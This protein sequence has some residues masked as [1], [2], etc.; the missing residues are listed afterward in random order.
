MI[1]NSVQKQPMLMKSTEAAGIL[2]VSKATLHRWTKAGK[3]EC[4][5]V[6]VNSIYFTQ[7]A[8]D[9]FIQRNRKNFSPRN[10]A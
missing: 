7:D 10:V 3:I 2:G 6:E 1:V 8:L 9:D 5:Q 4:V